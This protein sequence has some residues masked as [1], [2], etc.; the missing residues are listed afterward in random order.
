[1]IKLSLLLAAVLLSGAVQATDVRTAPA[2]DRTRGGVIGNLPKF[3]PMGK[4]VRPIY[5]EKGQVVAFEC[6]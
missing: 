5:N 3:C 6:V 2:P 1:M 4:T